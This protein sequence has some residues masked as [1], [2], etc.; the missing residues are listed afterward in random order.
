MGSKSG[1]QQEF[2]SGQVPFVIP[3]LKVEI[4]KKMET[5]TNKNYKF[6]S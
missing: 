3:F 4:K 1:G 2:C 6:F 5:S